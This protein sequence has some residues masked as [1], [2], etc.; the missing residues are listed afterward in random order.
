MAAERGGSR[1]VTDFNFDCGVLNNEHESGKGD[2]F[3]ATGTR[4]RLSDDSMKRISL[5][6]SAFLVIVLCLTSEELAAIQQSSK[7]MANQSQSASR[8]AGTTQTT[9]ESASSVP[10]TF[11]K[12]QALETIPN[13]PK[14]VVIPA[15]SVITV[16]L[17]NPPDSSSKTGDTFTAVVTGLIAVGGEVVVPSGTAVQGQVTGV[18]AKK[19]ATDKARLKVALTSLTI[20]G[21]PY[22]IQTK[23]IEIKAKGKS[24]T[25]T[26]TNT[27]E[28]TG[29]SA[30]SGLVFKLTAPVTVNRLRGSGSGGRA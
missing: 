28:D 1:S 11:A 2:G 6:L 16:R 8:P 24:S 17:V 20:D 19:K 23:L 30:A 13:T 26:T 27:V 21:T 12:A 4:V 15:G 18:K 29:A 10:V 5:L 14:T 7:Q 25:G 3:L 22:Q 9:A